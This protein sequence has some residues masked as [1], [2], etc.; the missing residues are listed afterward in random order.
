MTNYRSFRDYVEFR[1]GATV[2]AAGAQAAGDS[3]EKTD[4]QIVNNPGLL[5]KPGSANPQQ[6]RQIVNSAIQKKRQFGN[7]VT[8]DAALKAAKMD[9]DRLK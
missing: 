2:A 5:N 6:N 9:Q 3:D 8:L 4:Q 7:R 1:E